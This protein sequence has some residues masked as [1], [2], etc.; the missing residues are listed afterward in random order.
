MNWWR[1]AGYTPSCGSASPA[2]SWRIEGGTVNPEE[3]QGFADEFLR[4]WLA[5]GF[6]S[7]TKRETELLVVH[8]LRQRGEYRGLSAYELAVRLR[9]PERPIRTLR[10]ESALKYEDISSRAVLGR[11]VQRLAA[12]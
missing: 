9:I 2:A 6:G 8:L 10:L 5:G 4:H 11:I 1:A 12:Q 3:Q 7:M